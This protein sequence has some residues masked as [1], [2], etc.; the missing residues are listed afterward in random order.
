MSN[1][2]IEHL[3]HNA[4]VKTH[5]KRENDLCHYLPAVSGGYV[6]HFTMR[7]MKTENPAELTNMLK[8]YILNVDVP[9]KVTPKQRAARGSRK[10]R[11]LLTF[12]KQD[13]E[14]MLH[15]ARSAGDKEM[16]RK[17]TPKKDLKTIK[18]ELLSSIRHGRIEPD[19][20]TL[21]VDTM[22]SIQFSAFVP[23]GSVN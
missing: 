1:N 6:H 3:L 20:W 10:R 17:L 13:L 23:V 7:K 9:L 22:T 5:A 15:M 16:V 14:K 2:E 4:M 19:L 8:T 11:D 21:Y 12:S 18:R